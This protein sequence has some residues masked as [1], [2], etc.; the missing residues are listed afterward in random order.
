MMSRRGF[1]GTA[2]V[3]AG[4]GAV[5]GRAQAA[6]IPEAPTTTATRMQPPIR[7]MIRSTTLG[8]PLSV[9]R[10]R[11]ATPARSGRGNAST[12][13]RISTVL[14]PPISQMEADNASSPTSPAAAVW[15]P[16]SLSADTADRPRFSGKTRLPAWQSLA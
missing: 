4:A 6:G 1:L 9:C 3:L 11:F 16:A 10:I 2:A 13:L 12:S 7:R 15:A 8:L 5:S 14:M